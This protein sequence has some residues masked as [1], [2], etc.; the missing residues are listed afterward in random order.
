M[1]QR[2]LELKRLSAKLKD[3]MDNRGMANEINVAVIL[4]IINEKNNFKQNSVDVHLNI[5]NLYGLE[6]Y[7]RLIFKPT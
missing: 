1:R 5:C 6:K 2:P 7:G 4:F 3:G